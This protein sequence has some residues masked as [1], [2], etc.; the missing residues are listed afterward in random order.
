MVDQQNLF[1]SLQQMGVDFFTGVPDSLLNDFCLYMVKNLPEGHHVM[2]ANEGNA[3]G[4]ALCMIQ[5]YLHVI[6]LD[7]TVYYVDTV[8]VHLTLGWVLALN[9]G[10]ALLAILVLMLPSHVIAKISPAKSIRFE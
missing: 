4:I 2:A 3:I 5:K 1:D 6:P 10:T 7:P 9:I 8:P